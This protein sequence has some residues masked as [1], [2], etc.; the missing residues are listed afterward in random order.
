MSEP[1]SL[2]QLEYRGQ[3][4]PTLALLDQILH[5]ESTIIKLHHIQPNVQ[6]PKNS[7]TLRKALRACRVFRLSDCRAFISCR[8]DC[9]SWEQSLL[10]KSRVVTSKCDLQE[11]WSESISA[12]SSER[13]GERGETR[14]GKT[15]WKLIG[16]RSPAPTSSFIG[17]G[18]E[19]SGAAYDGA[20][21]A[22]Y[23]H[24]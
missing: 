4:V 7:N 1:D 11:Y 10:A 14:K 16:L 9:Y 22:V 18:M 20:F 3:I 5:E 15:N 23:P 19:T 13:E 6:T 2:M 21:Q 8:Q 24:H 12:R 17:L